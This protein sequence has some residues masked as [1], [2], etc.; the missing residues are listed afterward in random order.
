MAEVYA[1]YQRPICLGETSHFGI[2]RARWIREIGAEVAAAIED[3]VPVQGVCLYPLID[4]P[5]WDDPSHWH[6]SGLFDMVQEPDGTL[7]RVLNEDYAAGLRDA[8][9]VVE[10]ARNATLA[11]G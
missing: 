6:N 5:D 7:R 4:R 2:G 8:C 3:G 11:A 10:R 1:R 9:T